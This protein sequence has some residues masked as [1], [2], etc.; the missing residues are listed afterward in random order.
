MVNFWK[1]VVDNN[2]FEPTWWYETPRQTEPFFKKCLDCLPRRLVSRP[3]T[4]PAWPYLAREPS[5]LLARVGD[6]FQKDKNIVIFF[7]G[8]E[9]FRFFGTKHVMIVMA[10]HK[11]WSPSQDGQMPSWNYLRRP[12]V[13]VKKTIWRMNYFCAATFFLNGKLL[14]LLSLS[15]CWLM[16]WGGARP[17]FGGSF[18]RGSC[19]CLLHEKVRE[20]RR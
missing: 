13:T 12:C 6:G 8:T 19:K 10:I 5:G 11:V 20:K 4:K 1:S 18:G 17:K 14:V 16:T 15:A 7:S 9:T 2:I 3:S